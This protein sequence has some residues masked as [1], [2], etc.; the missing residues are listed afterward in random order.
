MVNFDKICQIAQSYY[1]SKTPS[2]VKQPEPETQNFFRAKSDKEKI[3]PKE[4]GRIFDQLNLGQA[5]RLK[6]CIIDTLLNFHDRGDLIPKNYLNFSWWILI[7]LH[8]TNTPI[9]AIPLG[10]QI[11][12]S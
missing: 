11:F 6:M 10:E 7:E 3:S 8:E 2:K 12:L 9:K 5:W 4:V 1:H